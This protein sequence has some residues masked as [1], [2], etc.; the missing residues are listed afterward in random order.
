MSFRLLPEIAP[1]R[2]H[3][4]I[5]RF[6]SRRITV[7]G[8]VMLDRFM[9][10]R[11]ARISPEA[12]VPV[13]VFDHEEIRLGGAANVAHN[14]RALG[15]NVDLIG[16]VG[17]DDSAA[18]LTN[19]LAAKGI[20]ATGLITDPQRRTTTKMRVVTSRNQQVSRIDFES[21]HEVGTAIEE[22][23]ARQVEMRARSTQVVLVSDYQKGVVT[24]RSMAS[25]LSFAH[26]AGVPVIV[27]P[28]VPHIEYYAGAAL[29]TP[30]HVE[31]ESATN[32]RI[33]SN[34]DAHRAAQALRQRLGVESVLITRGEHGMWLDH[35]GAAGY[36]PASAREV[37]DV[38]GAGDTVIATLALAI[39]SGAN[40][41]EAARLANEA[42]SIVVGKFGAATVAPAELKARFQ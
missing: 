26:A 20:A 4:L 19:E 33:S 12:P 30:N 18:Q 14:L 10:G 15:S 24:R 3:E 39:A 22:A 17:Q 11:V 37:A 16:V 34:E 9:I 2:A 27:D 41:F 7:F 29:V 23:L 40:M 6:A 28:K 32:S 38:T 42:A 31:A 25:L 13:V 21:D 5:D 35:A 8:D 1:G 36:L